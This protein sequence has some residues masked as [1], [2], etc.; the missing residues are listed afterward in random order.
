M[1]EEKKDRRVRRTKKQLEEALIS[2]LQRK[3]I[4][5]ISVRELADV[6]DITRAT[7]YQHYRDPYDMLEQMQ[8]EIIDQIQNIIDETKSGDA[9]GFFLRIFE[10]MAEDNIRSEILSFDTGQGSGYERIG[11]EMHNNYML[12]W[13]QDF[14]EKNAN[15]YEYYR[16]Y[17]VFG[18]IAIVENWV[19]K[20]KKETPLEMA[21]ITFSLMPKE[22]MY[23]K[24]IGR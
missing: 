16:Y 8:N 4:Q 3:S 1:N 12:R 10:Y 15:H 19:K 13:G 22:K 5:K 21:E 17:I 23:L 6:A 18:C 14:T 2:M 24:Q 7:F 20:G 9:K 11:N